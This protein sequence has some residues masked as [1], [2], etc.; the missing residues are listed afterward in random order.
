MELECL[1]LS[2]DLDVP[3]EATAGDWMQ[4]AAGTVGLLQQHPRQ[5]EINTQGVSAYSHIGRRKENLDQVRYGSYSDGL[6]VD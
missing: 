2:L 1:G 6:L 4:P 3:L 5:T